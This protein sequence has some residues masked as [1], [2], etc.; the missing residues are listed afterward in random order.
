M[1]DLEGLVNKTVEFAYRGARLKLDL[2][3]ALFSS[4][5]IDSGTR[6]L[7]K[8]I[9]HDKV[10]TG[11]TRLL[12]SGCGTGVIGIAMAASCPAMDVMLR[13]RDLVALAFSERN[14]WRNAIPATR[15]AIDGK[16]A[17]GI[18]R[19]RPKH[20]NNEAR[21]GKVAIRPALLGEDDPS[22]PFGAVLSNLPAKAGTTV[23]SRFVVKDAPRLLDAGGRLAFVIVN[24]LAEEASRWCAQSPLTLVRTVK[25]KGHSVF[26]LEKPADTAMQES[27][28]PA[29]PATP[30]EAWEA[31]YLR[32]DASR[33]VGRYAIRVRG[34]W[35]LPE[36]DTES[37]ATTLAIEALEKACAGSLVRDFL[38][39]EPGIGLAALWT[40]RAFGPSRIRLM[41]RDIL[42][43]RASE[44]NFRACAAA[45]QESLLISSL[46]ADDG[47][48]DASCDAVLWNPDEIPGYDA[49]S[50]A[51]KLLERITKKGGA[52]VIVST[53]TIISRFD[54]T[55]PQ[56]FSRLGE[57]KW[58]GFASCSFRRV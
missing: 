1:T 28:S 18:E 19:R 25:G 8:E 17:D 41:S 21:T 13:D 15:F 54:K 53:P 42:A 20:F 12:D 55:K 10:I 9:A 35:G 11:A 2:S 31:A 7:L 6:L 51:W 16:P 3:H 37:H 33:N 26:I 58:K 38:V 56:G 27:A 34:W 43:L 48:A 52:V 32:T 4:F 22:G 24:T 39:S 47:I 57:K 46:D 30:P 44:N 50:P 49:I 5:D 45:G 29:L 40:M 36:F 14:C 23:L